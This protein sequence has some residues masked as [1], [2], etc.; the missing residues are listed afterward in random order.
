MEIN[1]LTLS[2]R[3]NRKSERKGLDRREEGRR[4]V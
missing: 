4:S 2:Q 1:S 3:L